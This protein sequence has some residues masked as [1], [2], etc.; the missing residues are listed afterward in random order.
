MIFLCW[1]VMGLAVVYAFGSVARFGGATENDIEVAAKSEA[2][3]DEL[4][5]QAGKPDGLT[6]Y[7]HT[8]GDVG[9]DTG[10]PL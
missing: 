9:A 7:L 2:L 4:L 6:L 3:T 1:L 8:S 5:R 10:A